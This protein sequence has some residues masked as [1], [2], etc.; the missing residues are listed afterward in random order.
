MP[1]LGRTDSRLRMVAILLVF[2]VIGTAASLRLGYWQVVA[3]DELTAQIDEVKARSEA[4]SQKVVRAD[5]VDRDGVVLAKTSSFDKLVAY[6]D[7]IDPD[8]LDPSV[9][10]LAALLDVN[11]GQRL[12]YMET[13]T[14][15]L[16]EGSQFV[17]LEAKLSLSESEKVRDA[18][19][20]QLLP[21]YGL[22]A[23]DVRFYP[24]KGGEPNTTLASHILGFV[25]ADGRGGEGVER[26][27]D[28]RLTTLDPEV[29]DLAMLEGTAVTLQGIEPEPLRLTIDASLQRAVEG[30]LNTAY[31]A[32]SAKSVS[33]LVMD[34]RTGAILAAASVPAYDAED[35]AAIA[36]DDMSTLVNRVFQ[37]AYEP[38]S[39]MKIFT[40]TAALDLGLVT[41]STVVADQRQLEFWKY[42]VRNADHRSKGNLKVKDVIALSRNVATA[43]IAR[44][45]APNSTQK[46]ARR[47]YGLW[48]KLGMTGPT[49]V[50][51][52]GEAAGSWYD[53][54]VRQWAPVDL[55]NRAFG[56][57]VSVTLPQLARGISAIV[58]G[59]F[60][61]QPHFVDDGAAGQVEP[62]RVLKAKTATQA[63]EI[64]K[65]V[66]GS[67]PWYAA[68]SL[69]PGYEIGGKTGTAQIWDARKGQWKETRFNHSFI[70]FVGGR[71]QEY[72]ITVRIEEPKPIK[73]EQ[74]VIPLRIESYELFQMVAR[75]TIS[76]LNMKR[77]RDPNAGLPI[78]GTEA[79][80]RLDP[81]RNRQAVQAAKSQ[82]QSSRQDTSRKQAAE[83]ATAARS[84]GLSVAS[85]RPSPSQDT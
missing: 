37:H 11:E 66:T 84:G 18:I 57:G 65:H 78:I 80:R 58:N 47:L 50:D 64:L 63:K 71:W 83:P 62:K 42:T 46:A 44:M 34:P 43:K 31:I 28:E 17:T 3:S 29:V 25:R 81:E 72:V 52:S 8:D 2:A 69:I 19:E 73:I 12:A 22:E 45:L 7:I 41:P 40:V 32:N 70:G 74:G 5:I 4:A 33:A 39:V 82:R 54:A 9:E 16:E 56:Q 67:V 48:E 26:Y 21:G 53:P 1:A 23:A 14:S 59:G 36:N 20:D 38:G 68:G 75:A 79:A 60:L 77:S 24:R 27:Y 35:Y 10:L 61:I 85:D 49:G 15:G 6:P 13:L 76:E 55:A 30:E 51:I